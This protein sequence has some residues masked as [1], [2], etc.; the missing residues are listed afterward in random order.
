MVKKNAYGQRYFK[1]MTCELLICTV[2]CGYKASNNNLESL[3]KHLALTH[4]AEELEDVS[5][6]RDYLMHLLGYRTIQSG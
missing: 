2:G 6:S 1:S 5:I 3:M 4:S